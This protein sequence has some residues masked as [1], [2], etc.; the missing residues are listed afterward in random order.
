MDEERLRTFLADSLALWNVEG[1]IE[2]SVPPVV[3]VLHVGE[4]RIYVE[5]APS[6][7]PFRWLVRET[8]VRMCSS[9]VGV[10]TELRTLLSIAQ[11]TPPQVGPRQ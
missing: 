5:R 4:R 3:A 1:T 9:L 2:C 6:N 7:I 10:V 8:G 11:S